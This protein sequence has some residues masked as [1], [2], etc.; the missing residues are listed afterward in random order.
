M[1]GVRFL[2]TVCAV[3]LVP[4]SVF[5]QQQPLAELSGGYSYFRL[6]EDSGAG[7][8]AAD[9]NGWSAAAKLNLGPRIGLVVDFGG[10]YGRRRMVHAMPARRFA[11]GELPP[12]HH[13]V[14]P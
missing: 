5:A 6:S 7:L 3:A 2:L 9:L 12:A 8:T 4:V 11:S 1:S 14:R 10:N 13:S